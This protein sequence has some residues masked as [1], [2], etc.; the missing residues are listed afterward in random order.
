MEWLEPICYLLAL[1]G[2]ILACAGRRDGVI[3]SL[4]ALLLMFIMGGKMLWDEKHPAVVDFKAE[5]KRLN[6]D[7]RD[8]IFTDMKAEHEERLAA[9][10]AKLARLNQHMSAW[11]GSMNQR[12]AALTTATPEQLQR[13]NDEAA[14]YKELHEVT[15]KEA[16]DLQTL[17][18]KRFD[19]WGSIPDEEYGRYLVEQRSAGKG[20]LRKV[21]HGLAKPGSDSE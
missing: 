6:G 2:V 4:C 21:L 16:A 5:G 20:S 7:E 14:A 8:D 1:V 18:N 11:Y 13:F 3:V 10:Q 15:K 12:R 9:K 19:G 17:L